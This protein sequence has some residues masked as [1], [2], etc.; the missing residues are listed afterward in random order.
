MKSF[1]SF[2][3]AGFFVVD[4]VEGAALSFGVNM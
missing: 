2:K 4:N 1:F 3:I